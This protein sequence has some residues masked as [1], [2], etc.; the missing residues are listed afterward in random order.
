MVISGTPPRVVLCVSGKASETLPVFLRGAA[1]GFDVV[2][3]A[4]DAV[5]AKAESLPCAPGSVGG[6]VGLGASLAGGSD[7]R[8]V[9][10]A[11][12]ARR[13][14]TT[15]RRV[16]GV[17]TGAGLGAGLGS[18]PVGLGAGGA[19]STTGAAVGGVLAGGCG[20]PDELQS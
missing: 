13:G 6:S 10:S 20:L 18:G 9:T 5:S 12:A 8:E 2:C 19:G 11:G 4:L 1:L 17:G 7:G 16:V 3:S 15:G 14:T